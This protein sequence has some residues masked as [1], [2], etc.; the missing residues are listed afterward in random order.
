MDCLRNYR[1][2]GYVSFNMY[3]KQV[4]I[5]GFK[6]YKEQIATEPFSPKMLSTIY[7]GKSFK[8]H[9]YLVC[10]LLFGN[11]VNH[12]LGKGFSVVAFVQAILWGKT[13]KLQKS[14]AKN[15]KRKLDG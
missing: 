9:D 11:L 13:L 12:G 10:T 3:I 1:R 2:Y 7:S 8:M 14:R 6:S 4:V 15:Y 5:E